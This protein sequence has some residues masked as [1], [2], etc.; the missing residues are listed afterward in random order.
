MKPVSK[1]R[2]NKVRKIKAEQEEAEALPSIPSTEEHPIAPNHHVLPTSTQQ[3][4]P[5]GSPADWDA[6]IILADQAA[7]AEASTSSAPHQQGSTPATRHPTPASYESDAILMQS[8]IEKLDWK[9]RRHVKGVA[10][11]EL[12]VMRDMLGQQKQRRRR[13]REWVD[14]LEKTEEWMVERIS[15][16]LQRPN[17]S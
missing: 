13:I 9:E 10:L 15:A 7:A 3:S 5:F 17:V 11:E 8:D 2:P 12:L 14:E 4:D 1:R 16:I 6:I